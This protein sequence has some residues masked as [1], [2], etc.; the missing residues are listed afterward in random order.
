MELIVE[1]GSCHF[2]KQ[3]CTP[4]SCLHLYNL[5]FFVLVSPLI[6]ASASWRSKGQKL[7][8]PSPREA[9]QMSA[10]MMPMYRWFW[11]KGT[12]SGLFQ[13]SFRILLGP[14][15]FLNAWSECDKVRLVTAVQHPTGGTSAALWDYEAR[16]CGGAVS[17]LLRTQCRLSCRLCLSSMECIGTYGN[18]PQHE[19]VDVKVRCWWDGFGVMPQLGHYLLHLVDVFA[20][21]AEY[22]CSLRWH[23]VAVR[24][25]GQKSCLPWV[26]RCKLHIAAGPRQESRW[27][28]LSSLDSAKQNGL[29]QSWRGTS[30]VHSMPCITLCDV[31]RC[32][33]LALGFGGC[34]VSRLCNQFVPLMDE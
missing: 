17:W 29:S 28:W 12:P 9:C 33:C 11:L 27:A 21:A 7:Q 34:F 2:L 23:Q 22:C 18:T 25:G 1:W 26:D 16:F 20:V 10:Q 6:F 31:V 14:M 5:S 24:Q 15:T 3:L 4:A 19:T 30:F 32:A 8:L 13:D